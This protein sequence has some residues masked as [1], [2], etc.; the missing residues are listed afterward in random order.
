MTESPQYTVLKK[1]KN[2]ELRQYA[3]Y[4][5]AEVDVNGS[6][7]QSAISSGFNVLAGYIFGNNVSRESIAMTTP[8][9]VEQSQKIAMT[10]P[11]KVTGDGTYTVAFIMPSEFTLENLPLPKDQRVRFNPMPAHQAA[12]IRFSGYFKEDV[13]AR[14]KQNLREWLSEQGLEPAG[15]F[16]VAGYNPP[17]VPG[18]L[19]RN[20][21][22]VE[23]EGTI[24]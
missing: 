6:S 19:A 2:I 1:D 22:M 18:I 9:K 15:D 12:V 24:P 7:Y 23:V 3:G 16:I 8:V 13:I 4:I 10:T 5:Q 20:E 14:N 21:V 11:V 17:W